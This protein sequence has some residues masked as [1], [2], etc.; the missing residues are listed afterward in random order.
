MQGSPHMSTDTQNT[1]FPQLLSRSGNGAQML[2]FKPNC[3]VIFCLFTNQMNQKEWHILITEEAM[4]TSTPEEHCDIA[5][6]H[7]GYRDNDRIQHSY[8]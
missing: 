7:L 6:A 2:L 8:L 5:A 4:K 3:H 1:L